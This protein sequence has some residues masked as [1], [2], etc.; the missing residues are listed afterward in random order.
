M[1]HLSIL[2]LLLFLLLSVGYNASAQ[3]L[4]ASVTTTI[5]RMPQL[6]QNKLNGVDRII[7]AYL[8][9]QEWGPN[10]YKYEVPVDIQIV[11]TE[12][13]PVEFEDR[14]KATISVSNRGNYVHSDE[15]WLFV[16]ESGVQLQK[17]D[18]FESFRSLIDYYYYMILGYEFDKVKKFGGQEYFEEAKQIAQMARLSSRY[19]LGWDK[20][21]ERTE[22]FIDPINNNFRYL[23]FLYYTGEWLY[24]TERDRETAKQYLLYAI[25]QL[26]KIRDDSQLERFFS[27]N[28]RN[29]AAALAEYEEWSSVSKL[30]SVDTDESHANYYE[31]LLRRR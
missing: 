20:R 4:R 1:R 5:D 29:Y 21:E 16:H 2:S 6:N 14:Y 22:D 27:L 11:F 12:A 23:N 8:N 24:Y 10:E 9:Q 13:L 28:Y 25:K 17:T 31:S 15:R 3:Q 30:A 7:S 19:F 18:Q 26:D